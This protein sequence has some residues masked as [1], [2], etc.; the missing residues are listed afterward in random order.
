MVL[1]CPLKPLVTQSQWLTVTYA[2]D[3]LHERKTGPNY[4]MSKTLGSP[5]ST[6]KKAMPF[7]GKHVLLLIC[8]FQ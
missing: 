7:H 5:L 4:S 8:H 3:Q 1:K 6:K 2:G